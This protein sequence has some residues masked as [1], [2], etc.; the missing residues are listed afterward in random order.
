MLADGIYGLSYKS[1]NGDDP[2]GEALAVLRNGKVL[3]SD[4]WGGMFAG[5]YVYDEEKQADTVEV[6]LEMPPDGILVTGESVGPEGA[7]VDLVCRFSCREPRAPAVVEIGGQPV[8][9]ELTYLGPLP[10]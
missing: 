5:S 6:R 7:A 10:G 4:P 2:G 8:A 9:L 3:G 1:A